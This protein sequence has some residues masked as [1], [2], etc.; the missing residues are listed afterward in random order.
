MLNFAPI[1][2]SGFVAYTAS[3]GVAA[4]YNSFSP[5][6]AVLAAHLESFRLNRTTHEF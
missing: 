6:P 1:E 2:E 3:F 5:L 4:T